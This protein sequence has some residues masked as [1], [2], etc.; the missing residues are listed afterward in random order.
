[1]RQNKTKRLKN[2]F[3]CNYYRFWK[4]L[5]GVHKTHATNTPPHLEKT[6]HIKRHIHN[7]TL[8][9]LKI[10]LTLGHF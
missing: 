6:Q 3:I 10:Y 7:T 5:P 1:M 2:V 9:D 8:I 4:L